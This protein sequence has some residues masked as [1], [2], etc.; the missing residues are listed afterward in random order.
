MSLYQMAYLS[1]ETAPQNSD[2]L[3]EISRAAIS[4]N[5]PNGITGMLVH[6]RGYFLQFME[7][8]LE[9]LVKCFDRIAADPRHE[10]VQ[11]L[12]FR[13]A[14]ER[15]YA[16]F[17]MGVFD[18]APNLGDIDAGELW[19]RLNDPGDGSKAHQT[20]QVIATMEELRGEPIVTDGESMAA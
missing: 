19:G 14:A 8:P 9:E 10:K 3:K 7:G 13:S 4:H 15:L 12:L 17:S 1:R 11:C 2:S 5:P 18:F 6:G 20:R 16:D